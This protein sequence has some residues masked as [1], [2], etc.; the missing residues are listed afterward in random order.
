MTSPTLRSLVLWALTILHSFSTTAVD[1]CI[2]DFNQIYDAESAISN[3][4]TPRSYILCPNKLYEVGYLDY[5]NNLRKNQDG[6]P[7]LPLRPNMRIQ[8]GDDGKRD[9]LCWLTGGDIQVDGTA[10][11]GLDDDH[12]HNVELVGLVFIGSMK[13]SLWV[14]KPGSIT[15]RDCEWKVCLLLRCFV[16]VA[17]GSFGGRF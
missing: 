7:P 5:N 9:N 6:G 14:T 13:H 10:I 12:L 8:C 16:C 3:T 17:V 2:S 11:S 1:A 4:N 15:F